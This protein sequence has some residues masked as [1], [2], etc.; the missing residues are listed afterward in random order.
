MSFRDLSEMRVGNGKIRIL[1]LASFRT[2][3]T[4]LR[5]GPQ[6]SRPIS[7]A[8]PRA[9]SLRG[10][11]MKKAF[12]L[13]TERFL[14]ESN[15]AQS[16]LVFDRSGGTTGSQRSHSSA[17]ASISAASRLAAA[18]HFRS[19]VSNTGKSNLTITQATVSGIAFS[20]K[21]SSLPMTVAP[22]QNIR[23]AA[24]FTPQSAWRCKRQHVSCN[25]NS[26]REQQQAAL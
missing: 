4:S 8:V 19:A 23:L 22:G 12:R 6:C 17:L 16:C 1:Y 11:T 21:G 15:F 26:D 3:S 9:R 18:A 10:G 7:P 24:A 14:V 2:A 25:V 5:S 13:A 20:Y